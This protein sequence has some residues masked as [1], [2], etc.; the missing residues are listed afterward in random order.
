MKEVYKII[1]MADLHLGTLA[2]SNKTRMAVQEK[3]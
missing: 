2:C 1:K 3:L